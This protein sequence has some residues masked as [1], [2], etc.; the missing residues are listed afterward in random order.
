MRKC[1]HG[2][3]G[4][5]EYSAWANMLHRC[6][7]NYSRYGARGIAVCQRWE[8]FEKFLE[9]MGRK[10]DPLMELD[11]INNDGNYEPGNCRWA[12]KQEQMRNRSNT[13]RFPYRGEMK[14]LTELLEISAGLS[15]NGLKRRLL[16]GKWTVEDA[17]HTPPTPRHLRKKLHR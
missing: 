15:I 16:S 5:P 7:A 17:V 1:K 6:R 2:L 10:P 14:A 9:D 13:P 4:T 12:T 3:C 11:R 8:S